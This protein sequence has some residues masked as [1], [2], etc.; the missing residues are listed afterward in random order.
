MTIC[1][2]QEVV[3]IILMYTV[4]LKAIFTCQKTRIVNIL[5][6][7]FSFKQ[8]LRNVIP[9]IYE[10]ARLDMNLVGWKQLCRKAWENEYEYLQ[11]D[12]FAKIG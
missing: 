8:I 12:R 5:N 3:A 2:L 11:I 1:F 4:Y 6:I 10:I 7:F 9:L